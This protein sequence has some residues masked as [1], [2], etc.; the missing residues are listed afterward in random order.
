LMPDARSAVSTS[1]KVVE[2]MSWNDCRIMLAT[3]NVV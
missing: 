1:R 3:V 2:M